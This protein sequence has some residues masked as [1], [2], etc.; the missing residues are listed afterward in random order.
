MRRVAHSGSATIQSFL[1]HLREA[2]LRTV[3]QPLS[4]DNQ[5]EELSYLP[6]RCFSPL[7]PRT[8]VAWH[9]NTLRQLGQIARSF[10]DVSAVF[11]R[12]VDG[13]WFP[14]AEACDEPEVVCHNDLGPWNAP[15]TDEGMISIIDWEM[16]SP[17]RKIW[18]VAHVAWNWIPCYSPE[19]RHRL[20]YVGSWAFDTR[21][22]VLLDS[23]GQSWTP[24]QILEAV[25]ARQERVLR[26]V[27]FAKK[28][29][30]WLL[31][32]WALVEPAPIEEDRAFT[33]TLLST[34]R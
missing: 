14:F 17:G 27:K 8:A 28:S 2:G 13:D 26:F 1:R 21:L 3:P 20:G 12:Q 7:E 5:F 29:D 25:I 30:E 34:L 4:L 19:E 18:D 6:G 9:D 24:R 22:K 31:Q 11:L 32:N 10:H 33:Q 16:A 15:I 23:Y